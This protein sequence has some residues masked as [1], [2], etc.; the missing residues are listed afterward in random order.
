MPAPGPFTGFPAAASEFL[1]DLEAHNDRAWFLA[2]KQHYESV[3]V[4]PS[5]AFAIALGAA[6]RKISPSVRAEP[7]V[8]GS[9]FRIHRDVRFSHDKRP[10]KTHV[11][12]RLRDRDTARSR[13]CTGPLYYLEF[14]ARG[15]R[16]GAGVK[17]FDAPTLAAYRGRLARGL[18]VAALGAAL[19]AATDAGAVVISPRTAQAPTGMRDLPCAGL[20]RWKGLF[21]LRETP[22]PPAFGRPAFVDFCAERLRPFAPLFAE[23]RRVALAVGKNPPP[24]AL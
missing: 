16:L 19:T 18:G 8:G 13:R 11:G 15:M 1:A 9:L 20:L 22:L 12:I 7:V 2:R 10:F 17:E 24:P 21:V 6:L 23:L 5:L 14:D 4:A 3:V